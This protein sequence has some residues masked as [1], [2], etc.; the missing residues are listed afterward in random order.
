MEIPRRLSGHSHVPAME[1]LNSRE[2]QPELDRN[3]SSGLGA[4]PGNSVGTAASH[5]QCRRPTG[6]EKGEASGGRCRS[7]Y[8]EAGFEPGLVR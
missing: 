4:P 3:R 1:P 5:T 6:G 2:E 8:S 7:M